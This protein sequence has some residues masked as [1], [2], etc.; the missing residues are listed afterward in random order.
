MRRVEW[1]E[2]ER[3][4]AC[5][6]CNFPGIGNRHR[7]LLTKLCGS[8]EEAYLADKR[9]WGQV[10]SQK[11]VK[12]LEDYTEKW[13]PE[14]EYRRMQEAGISLITFSEKAYPQ[15]LKNI[16]DSPY[17]IFVKGRL[18]GENVLTVAVIG[19]RECSEYGRYVAAELGAE[20]G[21]RGVVVVSGMARGID[22]ISQEA[23]LEAG[24]VS[25]GVLGCGVDICYPAQ[26]KELYDRLLH[27][28]AVL[29][30]Y[31]VGTPAL[32]R[33]FP[34]RNR[35]VSGLADAV[36]VIE[37]RVKSGTLITVDMALEQGREVY[38]VPGRVTDR[39]SDGCNRLI[40]Q[41]AGVFLSPECFLE[42]I[43]QLEEQK[44]R[45]ASPQYNDSSDRG[46][47]N[48]KCPDK[49]VVLQEGRR[50]E[51]MFQ[52]VEVPGS[53]T[54]ILK[55]GVE[56]SGL[57]IGSSVPIIEVPSARTEESGSRAE[58]ANSAKKE[59]KIT[60]EEPMFRIREPKETE[61]FEFR[62]KES[63]GIG[64]MPP[65][66]ERIYNLLDFYPK[67]LEEIRAG[68]PDGYDDRQLVALLMGLCL[69]NYA[70]QI[71]P[72]HFCRKGK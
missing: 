67:S 9:K 52:K 2:R 33:N 7:H 50:K 41:G 10:L 61:G 13:Q 1:E 57:G 58:E 62:M 14:K 30:P 40:R 20:L 26:N 69:E 47:K 48:R 29:S 11:Q 21:R 68:L 27:K 46:R 70:I 18:P 19:A 12:E 38:V 23:A 63:N 32:A 16:P 65:E 42:E 53:G 3:I 37:A 49:G 24:G 22:G 35:I 8:A 4:Y 17:G 71:S 54:E 25:V 56:T 36:V 39:L 31:P 6:L 43:L 44:R 64:I 72:G 5:W 51:V 59:D 66:P 60:M 15:R 45:H 34:P 55:S 28:G